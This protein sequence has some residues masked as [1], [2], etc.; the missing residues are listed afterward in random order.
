M[1]KKLIAILTA[2]MI[3]AMISTPAFAFFYNGTGPAADTKY[4]T[5][6]PRCDRLLIKFYA[7]AE[8]EWDALKKTPQELDITDWPL[9]RTYYG[10]FI[11]PPLDAKVNVVSEGGEF[12]I[13]CLDIN[14]NPNR[15]LG[16][17]GGN[18]LYPNPVANLNDADQKNDFNPTSDLNMRKA[19]LSCMDR[20]YYVTN[21]IGSGFATELWCGLPP[22]TGLAY[23]NPTYM[24]A[25]P[26]SPTNAA[27]YLTAGNFK[28]GGDGWR[29]WDMNNDGVKT[30]NETVYLKFVIRSDDTLRN[31]AGDAIAD[32][33]EAAPVKVHVNRMYMD[34]SGART[35][36]MAGKDAHL[37]TAGWSLGVDPDSISLWEGDAGLANPEDGYYWHPGTCYDTG[38]ANDP[39]FNIAAWH[40]ERANS[41][42][43]AIAQM[44]ICNQRMASQALEGPMWVA[45][46]SQANA[47][48]YVGGTTGETSYVGQYWNGTVMVTGYGS[49][50]YFGFM[51]MHPE[52]FDRPE[53]GT[54]RYGFKT[55]D[56]R[57]FNPIYAEWVWDN[58][59]LDEM[60]TGMIA[61]NPYDVHDR[62]P[63]MCKKYEVGTYNNPI[64][65]TCTKVT[66][67]LREDMTFSD[68]TPVTM[69]DVY[70]SLV[71]I[72]DILKSRGLPNPWWYSAVKN[73]LSFSILD[74]WTFE[75]LI[76]VKSIWAFGLSGA[77]NRIMP[78]HIWRTI[79]TTGDPTSIAPDKNLVASGPWRL[80]EY[81][82][83][84]GF[85]DMVANK[86]G[87][88]VTT[89]GPP[90]TGSTP[91]TS[92]YGFFNYCPIQKVV[93]VDGQYNTK[94]LA[95]GT[96]T[97][98][99][100]L[101]NAWYDGSVTVD[102]VVKLDGVVIGTYSGAIASRTWHNE[103]FTKDLPWGTHT[104]AVLV[105][106]TAP[107]AFVC[108][109]IGDPTVWNTI[110][111][112]IAGTFFLG[113]S[114]PDTKVDIQDVARASGA[115]GGLPGNAKWNAVVDQNADHKIDIVDLAMISSK[116]GWHYGIQ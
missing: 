79:V 78:E 20:T 15:Y 107:A 18:P 29:Y 108:T 66:F 102:K 49:D 55:T 30:D 111:Q 101:F 75:V 69:K 44:D 36:W 103:T 110:K 89:T 68:G 98:D 53:N 96:H 5:F 14:N 27:N 13:R 115:F 45:D 94:I 17:S 11:T 28:I 48:K 58:N 99:V 35:Q 72:K 100:D 33:L 52:G 51:S 114:V 6:G 8:G 82:S 23:Y 93:M 54:I 74:P 62:L 71:E 32:A 95:N 83:T 109:E 60:Y 56:I 81:S 76:N 24:Q 26:F 47:R 38:Y 50:S 67:Y 39:Q 90:F 40:V 73:I 116:F 46:A 1:N 88:T 3:F 2:A 64:Y 84:G 7:A 87:R 34:I 106:C 41:D 85:V 92:T 19:I 91:T 77:G 105:N 21:I 61:T 63:W 42:A 12:G 104:I 9:T 25:Y 22:V 65:G 10:Q 37:Y 4:E 16:I 97:I 57:L 70:F 31:Q 113:N 80:R 86:P 112:D 43:E 59:V